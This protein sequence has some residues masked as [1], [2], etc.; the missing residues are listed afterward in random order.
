[1][2]STDTCACLIAGMLNFPLWNSSESS[3][4]KFS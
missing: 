3:P 1:M 2:A 4:E